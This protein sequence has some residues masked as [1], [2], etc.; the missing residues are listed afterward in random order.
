MSALVRMNLPVKCGLG[1]L[2]PCVD[3]LC[4][5]V[6]TTICGLERGF[7]FCDHGHFPDSCEECGAE[8][9]NDEDEW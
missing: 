8:D 9:E 2:A 3:D 5:G 7:D 1:G 4:H 6:D